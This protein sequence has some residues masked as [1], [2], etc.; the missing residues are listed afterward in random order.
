MLDRAQRV[1]VPLE[2]NPETL[3]DPDTVSDLMHRA[4]ALCRRETPLKKPLAAIS[5]S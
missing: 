3:S 4:H 1:S 2:I 5:L